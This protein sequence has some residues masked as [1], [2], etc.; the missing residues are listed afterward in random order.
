[1]LPAA[2]QGVLSTHA[3]TTGITSACWL[4]LPGRGPEITLI[5]DGAVARVIGSVQEWRHY[6]MLCQQQQQQSRTERIGSLLDAYTGAHIDNARQS[7]AGACTAR[8]RDRDISPQDL[9]TADVSPSDISPV[10]TFP[11]AFRVPRM[12]PP[13][14]PVT[15]YDDDDDNDEGRI[16]FSVALSPKTKRTRN[17]KPKQ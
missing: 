9:S 15:A 12:F 5:S 16:N 4:T 8:M 17:N 13:L 7:L 11:P 10:Q 6:A 3:H 2:H 14:K 1:M